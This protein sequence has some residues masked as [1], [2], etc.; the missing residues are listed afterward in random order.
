MTHP[1]CSV[2]GSIRRTTCCVCGMW[3]GQWRQHYNRDNGYGI[4]ANCVKEQRQLETKEAVETS[5]GLP[6]IH[7]APQDPRVLIVESTRESGNWWVVAVTGKDGSW[8]PMYEGKGA[9]SHQRKGDC[10]FWLSAKEYGE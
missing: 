8:T 9:S 4:C 1:N 6:G 7:F 10:G 3:S 5:Y 2:C